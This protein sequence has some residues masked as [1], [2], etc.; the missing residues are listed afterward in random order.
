MLTILRRSDRGFTRLA[1][2]GGMAVVMGVASTS[3]LLLRG[4][5]GPEGP[6]VLAADLQEDH[7]YRYRMT[8]GMSGT[9]AISGRSQETDV[10]VTAN[11]SFRIISVNP[12]GVSTAQL[13]MDDAEV[14]TQGR[15]MPAPQA[16]VATQIKIA[17]DGRILGTG[18]G[19]AATSSLTGSAAPGMDQFLPLLPQRALEPGDTWEFNLNRPFPLGS[20]EMRDHIE[21][22]FTGYEEV[23]GVVAAV[24]ESDTEGSFDATVNSSKLR[25]TLGGAFS[26]PNVDI[27]VHSE[28]TG[29]FHVTFW[30]N[31]ESGELIRSEGGGPMTS[32]NEVVGGL[33]PSVSPAATRSTFDVE[34]RILMERL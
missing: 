1:L 30:V 10:T 8:M 3:A 28:G 20:G 19:S 13:R 29:N 6:V 11:V 25:E 33:P 31:P 18:A 16:E 34:M 22:E 7:T 5:E 21:G 12:E 27:D 15:T 4:P 17:P 26:D 2:V 23:D 14:T 9:V 32:A 24:V